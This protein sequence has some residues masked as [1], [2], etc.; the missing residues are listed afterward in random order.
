ME[1]APPS[2]VATPGYRIRR[3]V[4]AVDDCLCPNDATK[5]TRTS[6]FRT[7]R[8]AL[9]LKFGQCGWRAELRGQVQDIAVV[10]KQCAKL[11]S[12][13][14]RRVRQHSL[15]H[16]LQIAGRARD[17]LQHLGGRG[18]LLQRLA[19]IIRA[20]AQLVEKPCIL[21]GDDCLRGEV[22]NQLN[23]LV[24]ERP[25][26]LA[27]D[28]DRSNQLALFEHRNAEKGAGAAS[29]HKTNEGWRTFE[30]GLLRP[31]VGDVN[32]LPRASDTPKRELRARVNDGFTAPLLHMRCR[33][34][35]RDGPKPPALAKPHDPELCLADAR[36]VLQHGL[37]H[38]LQL[39]RRTA[40]D[41][42]NLGGRGLLLQRLAQLVEEPGVLDGD[43]R[44]GGEVLDQLDLLVG[45]RT[46]LLAIDVDRA[47]QLVLLEHGDDEESA[48]SA[49]FRPSDHER[50][51]I[52]IGFQ[53]S[54]VVNVRGLFR[55]DDSCKTGPRSWSNGATLKKRFES[56]RRVDVRNLAKQT[57]LIQE[58]VA[59]LGLTNPH[60]VAQQGIEHRIEFAGR[61]ADDTE[62]LRGRALLLPRLGKFASVLFELLFQIGARLTRP[63]NGRTCLRSGRTK[64]ATGRSAL[65]PL[66]RQGHL[67]GTVTGP[68]PLGIEPMN[69][70]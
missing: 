6:R 59:K 21:D 15:E 66:A 30:V 31:E 29:V 36:G 61:R 8:P 48:D 41:V 3:A 18:L 33:S 65:R 43:D 19:Q 54:D 51:T 60:R 28:G 67:V 34:I 20:L 22:R 13:D 70:R 55:A 35:H 17:D 46:Y 7:K 1:H 11:C 69:A 39:A 14:A 45:K 2:V 47:D 26:F 44:L 49:P 63:A 12:T 9:S 56:Q 25:H 42:E 62:H 57:A 24:G 64:L 16:R 53:V 50:I 38:R 4:G 27:V 5:D 40:D 23:L 10:A 32:D 68:L 52:Y 37:E 58:Q